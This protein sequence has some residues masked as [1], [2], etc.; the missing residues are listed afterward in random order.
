MVISTG[1]VSAQ[2]GEHPLDPEA[3]TPLDPE[4]DT[5]PVNRMTDKS[6]N[7]TS[8]QLHLRAVINKFMKT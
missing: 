3:D 1:G 8:L 2:R 6:K 7:I 4:A 5:P